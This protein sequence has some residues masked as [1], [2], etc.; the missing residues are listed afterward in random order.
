MKRN[1]NVTEYF[2][3][4]GVVLIVTPPDHIWPVNVRLHDYNCNYLVE[5][6]NETLQWGNNAVIGP[7]LWSIYKKKKVWRG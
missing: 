3:L 5:I 2:Y 6:I 4:G 1:V 7:S